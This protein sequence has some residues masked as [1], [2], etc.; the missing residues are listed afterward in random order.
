MFLSIYIVV[1][2]SWIDIGTVAMDTE[3]SRYSITCDER[4]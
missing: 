1:K 4:P 2:L 3:E